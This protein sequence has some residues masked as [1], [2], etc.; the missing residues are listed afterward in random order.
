M[1]TRV[2]QIFCNCGTHDICEL[3]VTRWIWILVNYSTG[4]LAQCLA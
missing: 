4:N 2:L 1:P 3:N